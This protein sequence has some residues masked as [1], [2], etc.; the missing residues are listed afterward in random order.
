[1]HG[2]AYA[3]H[4]RTEQYALTAAHNLETGELYDLMRDPGEVENRWDAPAYLEIKA[5]LLARLCARM[6]ETIDPLPAV[7]GAF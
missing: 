3:T 1:M 6:A 7:E 2:G 5:E 4:L